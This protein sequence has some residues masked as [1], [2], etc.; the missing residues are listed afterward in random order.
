MTH[1][2][3]LLYVSAAI[4][5]AE[6]RERSCVVLSQL[7]EVVLLLLF[8]IMRQNLHLILKPLFEVQKEIVV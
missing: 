2:A 5:D 3:G 4:Q 7:I 8:V 1:K 6:F